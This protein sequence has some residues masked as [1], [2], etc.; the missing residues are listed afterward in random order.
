MHANAAL[1]T[2]PTHPP[3]RAVRGTQD[4]KVKIHPASEHGGFQSVT[5]FRKNQQGRN[6]LFATLLAWFSGEE[7]LRA[8]ATGLHDKFKANK[9]GLCTDLFPMD[10]A[11]LRG[12]P[13]PPPPAPNSPTPCSLYSVA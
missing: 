4:S 9:L 8:V 5:A 13:P 2:P 6:A 1:Q 10:N 7:E 12:T 11:M 3:T